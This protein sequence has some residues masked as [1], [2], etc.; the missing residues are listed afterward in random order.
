MVKQSAANADGMHIT[1]LAPAGG[2]LSFQ[3]VATD[4]GQDD[5]FIPLAKGNFLLVTVFDFDDLP[6]DVTAEFE[7]IIRSIRS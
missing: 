6:S 5:L 4:K 3:V 2:A 7:R 1:L